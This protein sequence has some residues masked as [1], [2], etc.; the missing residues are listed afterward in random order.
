MKGIE[1]AW[2]DEDEV[3]ELMEHLRTNRSYGVAEILFEQIE[4]RLRVS[5]L[6]DRASCSPAD[7]IAALSRLLDRPDNA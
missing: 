7:L 5:F 1:A 6:E 4:G 2:L 3:H